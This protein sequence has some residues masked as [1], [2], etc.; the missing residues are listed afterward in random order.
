MRCR[1][2]KGVLVREDAA[3]AP[4]HPGR[5]AR[6]VRAQDGAGCIGPLSAADALVP[7]GTP[8]PPG[9]FHL[10][11][12]VGCMWSQAPVIMR[13]LKGL[14]GA[15]QLSVVRPA[16]ESDAAAR[17][18]LGLGAAA[19]AAG[20][21]RQHGGQADP[22][23]TGPA[24]AFRSA[25]ATTAGNGGVDGGAGSAGPDAPGPCLGPRFAANPNEGGGGERHPAESL[26]AGPRAH[27]R[28]T[29]DRATGLGCNF[30]F[31]VY[32]KGSPRYSG[33]VTTPVLY[34]R[35]SYSFALAV[36][37]SSGWK[38]REQQLIV[39]VDNLPGSIFP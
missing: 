13:A 9:R 29:P 4:E 22:A 2:E 18:H 27:G 5:D 16:A 37:S 1:L 23:A 11:V 8:C 7:P 33:D 38:R 10:V 6:G 15:V 39:I 31:E 36:H 35:P 3:R 25:A 21:Q 32:L 26:A 30:L 17:A 12:G 20:G 19:A 24:A 28:A 34:D 14:E